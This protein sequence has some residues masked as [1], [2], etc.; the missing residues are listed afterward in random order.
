MGMA[1][2]KQLSQKGA[3]E[4]LD[5]IDSYINVKE[6]VEPAKKKPFNNYHSKEEQELNLHNV[7]T[8]YCDM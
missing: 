8:D 3:E 4:I 5:I 6:T 1:N 2:G 7:L